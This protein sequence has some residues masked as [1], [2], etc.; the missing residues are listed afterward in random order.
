MRITFL[1]WLA[2]LTVVAGVLLILRK[3]APASNPN[4]LGEGTGNAEDQ[5]LGS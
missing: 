4:R 5:N 3:Q 2:I 1:G